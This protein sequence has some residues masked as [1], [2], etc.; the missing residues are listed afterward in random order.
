LIDFALIMAGR[1]DIVG[2]TVQKY[3]EVIDGVVGR[4]KPSFNEEGIDEWV[5]A[6]AQTACS[7]AIAMC[8][9]AAGLNLPR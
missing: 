8:V 5:Y 7:G 4:V 1:S 2:L 9:L 3:Q 6:A